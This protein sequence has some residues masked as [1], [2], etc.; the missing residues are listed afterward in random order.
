MSNKCRLLSLVAAVCTGCLLSG[1]FSSESRTSPA[2]P[3]SS[4]SAAPEA[5]PSGSAAAEK[6]DSIEGAATETGESSPGA[7]ARP[8]AAAGKPGLTLSGKPPAKSDSLLFFYGNDPDTINALIANDSVSTEFQRWVY[9]PLADQKFSN[10]D[11]FAPALAESW[12]F[13]ETSLTYTIH[14]RKGVKWHPMKL[15]NGKDLPSREVTARDVKFTFDCILN[16]SV[17]AASLRSYYEDPDA[18]EESEKYKIKV[19]VVDN[20]TVKVKW[21]KPYFQAAEFTL[22]I[23]IIPRHVYSVDASGEPISFD[24]SSK[25]FAEGFNNHW[26]NR[27]MCGTGPLIFKEWKKDERVSLE[28]NPDYWG[29]PFYFS[30]VVFRCIPNSNTAREVLLQNEIDWGAVPEKNLYLEAKEHP[31]VK[32]GKVLPVEFDYPAYRYVGWNLEREFFKDKRVRWA[33]SHAMPINQMIDVVLHG[34]AQRTTGP[35]L[36]GSSANDASIPEVPYDLDRA[37]ELLS[38]AGWK[39][40]DGSGVRSKVINDVKV[41]A[42]FDLMIFSDSP[43]FLT[44]AEIIKENCRKI[45]VDVQISPAKWALMLQKLR[46][47][48]FD[49]A[50]LGWAMSWKQDLFQIW[51]SSQADAPDSSN[52]IGYKNPELDKLIEQLRVTLDTGKQTELYHRMHRIIY[53]DQ[54][55]TFLFMEKRTGFRDARLDNI[56]FYKIRPCFDAREWFATSPRDAGN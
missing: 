11:E 27:Q 48:E 31:N 20:Y 9:E 39:D 16:P 14:L 7:K 56:K 21:S 5:S 26:A 44:I 50:M 49:A 4:S 55:Y 34:L 15:P 19:T 38:E 28:R 30:R 40:T 22:V 6:T 43:T 41:P 23:P 45:G 35:M 29:E 42:R 46:K 1:C 32:S 2:G 13:D 18:K 47:K 33:L 54:P 12:E 8:S 51:H 24:F 17:Q 10:P 36:P 52:S 3:A 37:A 25:E 53:D